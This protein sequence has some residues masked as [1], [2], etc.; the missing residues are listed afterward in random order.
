MQTLFP[1]FLFNCDRS[2][3]I[4]CLFKPHNIVRIFNAEQHFR[5]CSRDFLQILQKKKNEKFRHR[6]VISPCAGSKKARLHKILSVVLV[7]QLF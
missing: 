7:V 4:R 2:W 6:C 3:L 5:A 1:L